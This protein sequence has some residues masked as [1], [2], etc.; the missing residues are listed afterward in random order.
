MSNSWF[1]FKQFTVEQQMAAMKVCTDACLFG[2]WVAGEIESRGLTIENIL[3]IGAGTGLLS[4]MLAQKSNAKIDA[5]EIDASA[6]GQAGDNFSNS[7]WKERMRIIEGDIKNLHQPAQY[8][9]IISNPPFFD[10]DLQ[11]EDSSRN[12]ALHSHALSLE[13][14]V[15]AALRL[16]KPGGDF[17]ILLPYH[18][19]YWF[20]DLAAKNKLFLREQI[21]VKQTEKHSYFR[22]MLWFSRS[23]GEVEKSE[24]IIKKDGKYSEEFIR[25]LKDYYLFL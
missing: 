21:L 15:F 12:I 5:V 10:N 20:I 2:G 3:D 6:A 17:A 9:I 25:L 7:L 18:R 24:L 19:N 11:S 14:L 8:D 4:L 13:D 22:S 1:Q 16:L 23:M